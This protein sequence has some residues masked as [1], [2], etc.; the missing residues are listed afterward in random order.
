M[1][2]LQQMSDAA[3]YA[4]VYIEAVILGMLVAGMPA[5]F[6]MDHT[7]DREVS[8]RCPSFIR[9]VSADPDVSPVDRSSAAP[10]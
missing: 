7:R 10:R 9:H 3:T 4:L 5:Y 2:I 6:A 8:G 1:T